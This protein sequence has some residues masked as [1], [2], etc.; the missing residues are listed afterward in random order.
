VAPMAPPLTMHPLPTVDLRPG[1]I[2]LRP[3]SLGD[4]YSGV[5]KAVRGNLA[6]TVGLAFV[7]SLALLVP[8]TAL[9]TWVASDGTPGAGSHL[10]T[11]FPGVGTV[12]SSVPLT[13]FLAF[14]VG[15]AVLGRRVSAGQTWQGT[16]GFILR[17]VGATALTAL[18]TFAG[19]AVILIAPVLGLLGALQ[20]DNGS[21]LDGPVV[22]VAAAGVLA[23]P[24]VLF[25]STRLAFVPAAIVLERIGVLAGVKRS[26][27]LT[28]GTQFWRVLGIRILSA[29]LA[30][31]ARQVLTV[32]L[33]IL[34][35]AALVFTGDPSKV[36][37]WQTLSSGVA[38]LVAG[39][40]TTPFSAGVDALLYVDQRIRREG[41]DV[42][43]IGAAQAETRVPLGQP[44]GYRRPGPA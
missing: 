30:F 32:P 43:L 2:P 11:F 31:L 3:L 27:R 24:L 1:I 29:V 8:T 12:L 26:W 23:L 20:S 33:A 7:T 18:I 25:F 6:A 36:D 22:L 5:M 28:S 44:G 19:A 38:A 9:G 39:S 13:G 41:L 10:G 15:Q 37:V 40:L 34:G 14:V 4:V 42:Q 35:G 21:S 16:R 17:L